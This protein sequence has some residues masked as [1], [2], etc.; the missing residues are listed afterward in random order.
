M[1]DTTVSDKTVAEKTISAKK[2]SP[3]KIL[4]RILIFTGIFLLVIT[5][6]VILLL[7]HLRNNYTGELTS[8]TQYSVIYHNEDPGFDVWVYPNYSVSYHFDL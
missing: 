1:K 3:K 8:L 5:A 2:R 7:N 4:R 6:G